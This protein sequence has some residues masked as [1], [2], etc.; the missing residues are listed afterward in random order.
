MDTPDAEPARAT[1]AAAAAD[2][3]GAAAPMPEQAAPPAMRAAAPDQS[4]LVQGAAEELEKA[5]RGL[6]GLA[7]E[8]AAG[9]RRLMATMPGFGA[10]GAQRAMA[11]LVEGVAAANMRFADELLR[12][13][14]PGAVMELQR[15]FLRGYFDAPAQ[16][17]ALPPRAP[18][19][20]VH[21]LAAPSGRV[22]QLEAKRRP[23]RV[24]V[25][26]PPGEGR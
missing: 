2:A 4:R 25:S 24:A 3:A 13:A 14:G 21:P 8:T 11:R 7:E 9:M 6:A 26:G 19:A 15:R 17:G 16:G 12:R 20:A 18:E 1:A 22:V 10:G 23:R 5:G